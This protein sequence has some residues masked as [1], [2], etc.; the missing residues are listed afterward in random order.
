L[1]RPEPSHA[2]HTSHGPPLAAHVQPPAPSHLP[3]QVASPA[4]A[5][6][7]SSPLLTGP[8]MPFAEHAWQPPHAELQ[9]TPSAQ[10]RETHSPSMLQGS[11]R[12]L[13]ALQVE[14]VKQAPSRCAP[15]ATVQVSH[16]P[17]Q[18][19]SQQT[20]STQKP[21]AHSEPKLQGVP[22]GAPHK[23]VGPHTLG[24]TQ[25]SGSLPLVTAL[26]LPGA[27][28]LHCWQVPHAA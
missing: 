22:S 11:P 28:P 2:L 9:Q 18:T 3:P 25:L 4:Q 13:R 16:G 24:A 26:Q 17:L 10:W 21:V 27:L 1:Q 7:G 20:L 19:V 6:C 14:G 8:Q 23:P 12:L 5:P 15:L